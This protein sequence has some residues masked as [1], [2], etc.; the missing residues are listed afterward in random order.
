MKK[1]IYIL[2]ASVLV[3][4]SC[5]KD[6]FDNIGLENTLPDGMARINLSFTLPE[7]GIVQTRSATTDKEANF[8]DGVIALF[9]GQIGETT[10]SSTAK[11]IRVTPINDIKLENGGY[12]IGRAHV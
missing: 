12:K 5:S 8:Q 4:S 6:N 1:L 10:I 11:L 3:I 9:D 7:A 2:I